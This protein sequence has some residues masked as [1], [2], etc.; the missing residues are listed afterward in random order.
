MDLSDHHRLDLERLDEL[1]G[2][3]L[4]ADESSYLDRAIGNFL[5]GIDDEVAA[6]QR[7]ARSGDT[8]ALRS[9]AHKVAGA[10]LNLGVT[11]LGEGLRR[12]EEL[13]VD[14]A[15]ADATTLLAAL[16]QQ[17]PADVE[18]LRAYRREQFSSP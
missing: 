10:A 7:A 3:G 6:M 17:L 15:V 1:H 4:A 5:R 9:V 2:L 12:V 8:T 18:A 11:R 13:L 14:G 16:V